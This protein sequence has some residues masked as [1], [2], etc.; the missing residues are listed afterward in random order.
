MKKNAY[1]AMGAVVFL[2][3]CAPI[4]QYPIQLRYIPS[5]AG[6]VRIEKL[7]TKVITV[8][9]FHDQRGIADPHNIGMRIKS[10]GIN[11]PFITVG[12]RADVETTQAMK[13][14]LLQKGYTV[15]EETPQ[16]DLNPQTVKQEWGDW[17]IGGNIEKFNI[18]VKS[19]VLRTL[20]EC[21]LKLRVAVVDA[22]QKKEILQETMELS[23][24][25]KTV[26]FRLKIAD[27]MVNKLIS[28]AVESTLVDIEKR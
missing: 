5:A 9:S 3:A 27:R 15:R 19:S 17:V 7:Q 12:E 20:Y 11:I 13:G 16:W 22:R 2:F 6:Y 4:T 10:N 14:S 24:S 18:E 26:G 1:I 25:Y 8:A 21:T 23:S 28:R